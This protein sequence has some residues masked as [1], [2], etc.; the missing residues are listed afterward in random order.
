MVGPSSCS[1]CVSVCQCVCIPWFCQIYSFTSFRSYFQHQWLLI[2]LFSFWN[3]NEILSLFRYITIGK[4]N[5]KRRELC[6]EERKRCY[7][8]SNSEMAFTLRWRKIPPP[9][10]F[11]FRPTCSVQWGLTERSPPRES[12]SVHYVINS[13]IRCSHGAVVRHIPWMVKVQTS[14]P[15]TWQVSSIRQHTPNLANLIKKILLSKCSVGKHYCTHRIFLIKH[16]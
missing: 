14:R 5:R 7:W 4:L 6:C 15:T 12:S 9:R 3:L 11:T 13:L 10:L 8:R 2:S 16:L 1:M